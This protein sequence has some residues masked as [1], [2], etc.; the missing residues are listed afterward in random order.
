MALLA[1]R[2]RLPGHPRARRLRCTRR[3]SR[4]RSSR[5][6]ARGSRSRSDR[7][8]A[9][10][11]STPA[12]PA[13]SGRTGRRSPSSTAPMTS[14]ASRSGPVRS[15]SRRQ[16]LGGVGAHPSAGR[17]VAARGIGQHRAEV[18]ERLRARR[19]PCLHR[20]EVGHRGVRC[21]TA[22]R[23]RRR[24]RRGRGQ[25]RAAS[26]GRS[27]TW[28]DC[29]A[30]V[31]IVVAIARHR[32]SLSTRSAAQRPSR[33]HRDRQHGHVEVDAAPQRRPAATTVAPRR[34]G[35]EDRQRRAPW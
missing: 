5:R 15:G 20:Q 24:P 10:A 25:P 30:T 8:P 28:S 6:R 33:A 27:Q 4:S 21:R 23:H 32:S 29:V 16:V 22:C 1:E 13:R 7:G 2:R 12:S 14:S 34:L 9:A 35:G 19:R 18:A 11:R 3:S 17:G 26:S 31:D